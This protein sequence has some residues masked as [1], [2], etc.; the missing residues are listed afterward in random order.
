MT[1]L[2]TAVI[3]YGILIVFDLIWLG[4]VSKKYYMQELKGLL[5]ESPNIVAG[6]AVYFVMALGL[7]H[8]VV[9]PSLKL[10]VFN[11]VFMSGAFFGFV[12]YGV[13]DLTNLTLLRKWPISI[14]IIDIIWG[15]FLCG[16]SSY[17][18]FLFF[19]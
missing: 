8:F 5:R 14:T 13:Y 17:L 16:V 2:Y 6:V 15:S 12:M 4:F 7:A 18:S 3:I 9:L 10:V 1:L 19:K 11:N